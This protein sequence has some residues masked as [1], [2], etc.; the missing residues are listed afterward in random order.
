MYI[1]I[2]RCVYEMNEYARAMFD[3]KI[4]PSLLNIIL[5]FCSLWHSNEQKKKNNRNLE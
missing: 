4:H 2:Y 5:F 1:D 3:I